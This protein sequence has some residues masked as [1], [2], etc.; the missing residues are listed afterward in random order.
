ML[1]A[2]GRQHLSA[3]IRTILWEISELV[4]PLFPGNGGIWIALAPPTPSLLPGEG[5][6]LRAPLSKPFVVALCR[7]ALAKTQRPLAPTL[8][9][10]AAVAGTLLLGI[11]SGLG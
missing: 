5:W 7:R 3:S 1:P 6:G 11:T 2:P 4:F 8:S 9:P 10:L